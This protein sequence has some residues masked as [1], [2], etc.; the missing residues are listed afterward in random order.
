M[1]VHENTQMFMISFPYTD[2]IDSLGEYYSWFV[3]AAQDAGLSV[4]RCRTKFRG[5]DAY[6]I[7]M[8]GNDVNVTHALEL[9]GPD[10]DEVP[11]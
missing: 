6:K 8:T 5:H 1:E 9:L 11:C 10:D 7:I 4:Y 3:Q 2:A